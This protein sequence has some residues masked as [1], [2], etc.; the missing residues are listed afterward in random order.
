[1]PAGIRAEV[2]LG[3]TEAADHLARRQPRQPVALLLLAAER[4]DRIHHQRALHRRERADAGVA[5]LELLHDEAV[6]DV[7]EPGAAV[8]LGQVGAEHAELGH[9]R[10]QL[11]REASLDVALAD[12]RQ[13]VLVDEG[14]DGVADGALFLGE[15]RV[16][17]VE[18]DAGESGPHGRRGH[19][20][21][22]GALRVGPN[23][24]DSRAGR[25]AAD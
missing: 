2:G 11:L 1:M 17:P 15:E 3:E 19:A 12:D 10:D 6:R 5:A 18:V 14:A 20:S 24:T 23:L 25:H 21:L 7:V 8:L 22:G 13:H 16:E 4:V 9:L